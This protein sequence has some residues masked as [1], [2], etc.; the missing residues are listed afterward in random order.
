MPVSKSTAFGV[1]YIRS[2]QMALNEKTASTLIVTGKLDAKWG[3]V[4][5]K[6]QLDHDLLPTGI[7]DE[8]TQEE[9]E[10]FIQFRYIQPS[11]YEEMAKQLGCLKT[12]AQAVVQ[13]CGA[14]SG[15]TV[16]GKCRILFQR[17]KFYALLYRRGKTIEEME[18]LRL[19][20]PTVINPVPGGYFDDEFEY[21]RFCIAVSIDPDLAMKCTSW[22]R[23]NLPGTNYRLCGCDSIVSFITKMQQSE[24]YQL[25]AFVK[26]IK[27]C[28]DLLIALQKL[29]WGVFASTY[30]GPM[31]KFH[32]IDVALLDAYRKRYVKE[33]EFA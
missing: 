6:F 4:L 24:R 26:Y 14:R 12:A 20:Y 19:D 28:P 27:S 1:D 7:Y 18:Q 17:D 8:R 33:R 3:I 5:K 16:S 32:G 22:G 13:V 25:Q 11:D 9:L 23:F 2:L 30:F 29:E 15:F 10:P 31:A 21:D